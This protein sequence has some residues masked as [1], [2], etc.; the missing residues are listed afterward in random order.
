MRHNMNDGRALRSELTK[1]T[2]N[3][4][5]IHIQ[6]KIDNQNDVP[7]SLRMKLRNV[8][9][10]EYVDIPLEQVNELGEWYQ[11]K[12][13]IDLNTIAFQTFFWDIYVCTASKQE[14]LLEVHLMKIKKRLEKWLIRYTCKFSN[15]Y[16]VFPYLA[17][18]GEHRCLAFQYRKSHEYDTVY[19]K[20]KEVF[21]I[22]LYKS[23]QFYFKKKRYWMI[24]EKFAKKAQ[25]NGY[26]FFQYCCENQ[27]NKDIYYLIDKRS[28]D[29]EKLKPYKKNVISFMSLKHLIYIQAPCVLITTETRNHYYAWKAGRGRMKVYIRRQPYVF[30]QHGVF[31][32]KKVNNFLKES[33]NPVDLFITSSEFEKKIVMDYMGYESHEVVVTGLARWDAKVRGEKRREILFLPTWR[34]WLDDVT[35]EYF[36]ESDYYKKYLSL[37]KEPKLEALLKKYDVT[38]HFVLH[39]LFEQHISSFTTDSQHIII[40]QDQQI[41]IHE[42]LDRCAMLVTDYSSVA[43]EM[44]YDKKPV[45]F[46]RFDQDMYEECQGSYIELSDDVVGHSVNTEDELLCQLER[47]IQ[48]DFTEEEQF[49]KERSTYFKYC[50]QENSKRIYQEINQFLMKKGY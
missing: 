13:K 1:F 39:P 15:G 30:L 32:F 14:V 19:Y 3:K 6:G 47:Y 12:V 45:V 20:L 2:M 46:Y 28:K 34:N 9:K 41:S 4:N 27:Q 50:D 21:A 31:G 23:C 36:I 18:K 49:G 42:L 38:L 44:Y 43:W 16:L 8:V 24:C 37:L 48:T 35:T 25:D 33:A 22:W 29:Y 40:H 5:I 17:G 10:T 26:Y 7:I 11:F